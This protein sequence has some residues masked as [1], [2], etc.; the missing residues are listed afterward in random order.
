MVIKRG[1]KIEPVLNKKSIN[2]IKKHNET[3]IT[4]YITNLQQTIK[5]K[6]L[7]SFWTFP[8]RSGF[9]KIKNVTFQDIQASIKANVDKYKNRQVCEIKIIAFPKS[10]EYNTY[11]VV[12]IWTI[13]SDNNANI[14]GKNIKENGCAF[15]WAEEDFKITKFSFK[16]VEAIMH[17]IAD[18]KHKCSS[19]TGFHIAKV[20]DDLKK[21]KIDLSEYLSPLA[22]LV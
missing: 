18:N 7:Q 11:L 3:V 12:D 22:N 21:K 19:F 6:S 4:E 5:E 17:I 1:K 14:K 2:E 9:K 10:D 15:M 16:L 20:L 13:T 8:D